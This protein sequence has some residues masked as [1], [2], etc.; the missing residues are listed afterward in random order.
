[1]KWF[2]GGDRSQCRHLEDVFREVIV[3]S[4]DDD[5]ESEEETADLAGHQNTR[6]GIVDRLAPNLM[7]PSIAWKYFHTGVLVT[8]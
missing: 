1:M 6:I 3:I 5:S 4:D 7:G 8:C 2:S